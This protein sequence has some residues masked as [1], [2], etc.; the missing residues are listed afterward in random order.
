MNL[1]EILQALMDNNQ[2]SN[3]FADTG[4]ASSLRY[5]PRNQGNQ[6]MQNYLGPLA[7]Q[8]FVEDET[9]ENPW[10]GG[11]LAALSLPYSAGKM[12]A[13]ELTSGLTGTG[14]ALPSAPSLEQILRSFKGFGRGL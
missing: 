3:H 12:L 4:L 13:P 6:Q 8:K 5:S 14:Q 11:L 10:K 2:F 1:Q 9:K 7:A